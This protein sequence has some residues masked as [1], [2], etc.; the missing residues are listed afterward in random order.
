ML[1]APDPRSV[2]T[3]QSR[4]PSHAD[5]VVSVRAQSK[6]GRSVMATSGLLQARAS[7]GAEGPP[8]LDRL[9]E[10]GGSWKF[11]KV[12]PVIERRSQGYPG[13]ESAQPHACTWLFSE[14]ELIFSAS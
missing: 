12:F 13:R 4:K 2:T 14:M 10:S 9:Q 8:T 11:G 1:A 7:I 3:V 6:R 5:C